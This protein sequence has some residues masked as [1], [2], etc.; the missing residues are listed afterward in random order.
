MS[1]QKRF[2]SQVQLIHALMETKGRVMATPDNNAEVVVI[3]ESRI[4]TSQSIGVAVGKVS[5]ISNRYFDVRGKVFDD[6]FNRFSDN[7]MRIESIKIATKGAKFFCAVFPPG[8]IRA[9]DEATWTEKF[10]TLAD[11]IT[12]LENLGHETNSNSF[13]TS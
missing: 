1:Q 3:K 9:V 11:L 5:A 6:T 13:F 8:L 10:V 2:A 7:S 12:L 4:G